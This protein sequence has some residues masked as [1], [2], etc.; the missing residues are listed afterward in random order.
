MKHTKKL[1]TLAVAAVMAVGTVSFAA[2]GDNNG[3]GGNGGNG[4]GSGSGTALVKD[5]TLNGK[6]FAA[7]TFDKGNGAATDPFTGEALGEDGEYDWKSE[8]AEYSSDHAQSGM[9]HISGSA[10]DF[11]IPWY[12]KLFNATEVGS[13]FSYWSW[14][15]TSN[16]DW[17]IMIYSPDGFQTITYGNLSGT[18]GDYPSIC[19][20]VGR[21]AYTEDTYAAAREIYSD[22]QL[23]VWN[24]STYTAYNAA[25]YETGDTAQ[26]AAVAMEQEMYASAHYITVVVVSNEYIKFYRDGALAYVYSS[27]AAKTG[28]EY[29]N[30]DIYDGDEGSDSHL[31]AFYGA[32][33][34]VDNAII[35]AALTDEEVL[36]LYNDQMGASKTMDDVTLKSALDPDAAVKSEVDATATTN[37]VAAYKE[38]AAANATELASSTEG[39]KILGAT[40]F[41]NVWYTEYVNISPETTD[42][43]DVTLTGVLIT[44]GKNNWDS[45]LTIVASSAGQEFILRT[46][47]YGWIGGAN[48][49]TYIQNAATYN[50]DTFIADINGAEISVNFKYDGTKVDV[51]YTV[52]PALAGQTFTG[53]AEAT[54]SD[55]TTYTKTAEFTVPEEYT[56]SYTVN[57][58][59]VADGTIF[60][61]FS[62]EASYFIITGVEGG[63]IIEEIAE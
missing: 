9:A 44:D 13:S 10:T 29:F 53:A 55:G 16:S 35:G 6:L 19:Q 27:D 17:N 52:K 26:P 8:N 11:A 1:I 51:L 45:L 48:T 60:P 21:G 32:C 28:A 14:S 49:A 62:V 5:T 41:S 36:A 31:K 46:D 30:L 47:N 57:D 38:A 56:C 34:Y 24:G 20:E 33:G 42:A 15:D 40:D 54:L 37:A 59:S 22:A 63:S 2:C 23:A 7:Y 43:F 25:L 58:L 50:W 39:I 12:Q 3:N 61:S 4:G 18:C